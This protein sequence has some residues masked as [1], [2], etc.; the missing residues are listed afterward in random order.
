M[1]YFVIVSNHINFKDAI[2]VTLFLDGDYQLEVSKV[3]DPDD[4]LIFIAGPIEADGT[5]FVSGLVGEY[6][7]YK[8]M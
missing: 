4:N 5:G 7:I 2:P 8:V 6:Q 3:I 1:R